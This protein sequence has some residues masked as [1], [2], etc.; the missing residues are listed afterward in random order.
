[1]CLAYLRQMAMDTINNAYLGKNGKHANKYDVS[2]V[3]WV[4]T[5]PAIWEPAAKGF[6]REAAYM[7]SKIHNTKN[8]SKSILI[9]TCYS[10]Y[11]C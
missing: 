6:M 9:R 1:M 7:V 2:Q 8:L 4:L 10:L 5:V 11:Y 3:Q